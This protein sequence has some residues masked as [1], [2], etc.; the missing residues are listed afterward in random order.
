M[1][2]AQGRST[3]IIAKLVYASPH[4]GHRRCPG[5]HSGPTGALRGHLV[6]GPLVLRWHVKGETRVHTARATCGQSC[7]QRL[8]VHA[9][10]GRRDDAAPRR[11]GH[12]G[13]REHTWQRRSRH[14]RAC[15]CLAGR[16]GSA[17]S[18]VAA[19]ICRSRHLPLTQQP[20]QSVSSEEEARQ[21]H[22]DERYEH[23]ARRL[24]LVEN[25]GHRRCPETR[26]NQR[27]SARSAPASAGAPL[28][29]AFR[30][31]DQHFLPRSA[32]AEFGSKV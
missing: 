4:D 25:I 23:A 31:P 22:Q 10:R 6:Q 30:N 16:E 11:S 20:D 2:E 9:D 18:G 27:T 1:R 14:C 5:R 24:K 8:A 13:R 12:A 15:R 19:G 21:R 28:R 32:A 3:Y 17:V 26:S 29:A 7:R